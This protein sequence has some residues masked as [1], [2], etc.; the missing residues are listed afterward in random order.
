MDSDFI[1]EICTIST[2][3]LHQAVWGV[4]AT[5]R[6]ESSPSSCI[7]LYFPALS[8]FYSM[9]RKAA[10]KE[11]VVHQKKSQKPK[12]PFWRGPHLVQ[13]A[14]IAVIP[15]LLYGAA[16]QFGY[17]LDDKIVLSEN[18]F[19]KQGLAG[20]EGVFMNDSFTGFLGEQQAL[21]AG[22]RYRPLSIATFALEYQWLGFAPGFSHFVNILLYSITGL[23]LFR[24]FSF[25]FPAKPKRGWYVAVPFVAALLFLLHPVHTEVVANIK[26]RDE[27]LAL[28]LS[29]SAWYAAHQ[30][31][32]G[33]GSKW[34]GLSGLS[35][36]LGLL[37]KEN[38]ITFLAVIPLSAFF[39]T[40]VRNRRILLSL[41]PLLLATVFYLLLRVSATGYFFS[42]Q[43]NTSL[44]MNNPFIGTTLAERYATITYTLGLYLKLLL[45][46]HPLTHDY[47]PYHIPILN[48]GDWRVLVSLLLY[49]GLG[50]L[51]VLGFRQKRVWSWAIWYY[52]AT[53]SI[54]SNVLFSVGTMMNERFL[55]MPSVGFCFLLAW[56]GGGKWSAKIPKPLVLG[57]LAIVG[58]GYGYKTIERVPAWEN[59]N[60]LN[61]AAVQVSKNSARANQYMGYALY[62]QALATNDPQQKQALLEEA[63]PYIDKSLSIVPT[64]R[65]AIKTK[66][67]IQAAYYQMDGQLP[68]LLNEFARLLRYNH[69]G[70][71]DQYMEYLNRRAN[72]GQ[73]LVFYHSIGF[74]LFAKEQQQ[75]LL[76]E[77]YIGYGLSV[78]PN[79]QTLVEDQVGILYLKGDLRGALQEGQRALLRYPDS[80]RL[81]KY[82]QLSEGQ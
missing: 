55:Y 35:F 36:F 63:T 47:Y 22:A 12:R 44:I 74:E 54:V 27:L 38:T 67:G 42:P 70:F 37:A 80:E 68:P 28:L 30:Y 16:L 21:V 56:M 2:I 5:T 10:R 79:D 57:L 75:Y 17:V 13:A 52:A 62:R 77:K 33:R 11:K 25:Y 45:F 24:I 18:Q 34:L 53:L 64:Y 41:L 39:F 31:W 26:G 4:L 73:L 72:P 48:W 59:E 6:F 51:A 71:I 76:A 14:I 1:K 69:V 65:D 60:T 40:K 32:Q 19:V 3:L 43:A 78:A 49:V 46:P 8:T 82:I 29:L 66:A 20:L 61:R 23:L 58:L 9:A 15:F 50:V 7:Y 81:S